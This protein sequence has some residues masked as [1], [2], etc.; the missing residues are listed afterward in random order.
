M[1]G[2]D[3]VGFGIVTTDHIGV[4]DHFPQE[5]SKQRLK[6]YAQ[7]GGGTVGT[8]LVACARLGV[9]AAYLGRI[10]TGP[11][12]AFVLEDFQREGV[13][14]NHVVT[15]P[16]YDPPVGLILVNPETGSR[17][18]C[19]YG[20]DAADLRLE[21]LDRGLIES[22]QMLYLDA[23]EPFASIFCARWARDV[24]RMVFMDADN[25]T[26][27]MAA[28]LPL[29]TTIIASQG[30]ASKFFGDADPERAANLLYERFGVLCGVT[31]GHEGSYLVD[32]GTPFRQPAFEVDVVDTTGAGDVYHG[33]FAVG[34]LHGWPTRDIACFASAVAAM[35]CRQLGGRAGI[36]R[37]E[38]AVAFLTERGFHGAWER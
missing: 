37:Y 11:S 15:T 1:D 9:R 2:F 27:G 33:A 34:L 16:E 3:V 30:F 7:Q 22:S 18:I 5:D 24:G 32:A 4:L 17:T 13:D 6:R 23:R 31:A 25:L 38:Q 19:W 20:P 26:D 10:G 29:C 8:P 14:T 12:S 21:D 28:V 36:P 35:K